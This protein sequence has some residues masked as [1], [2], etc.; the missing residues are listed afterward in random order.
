MTFPLSFFFFVS[1]CPHTLEST[2]ENSV[3]SVKTRNNF[4][5][6]TSFLFFCSCVG[7]FSLSLV[8]SPTNWAT[9][10]Q[11]SK[12]CVELLLCL[13][14]FFAQG[15]GVVVE[16]EEVGR[17]RTETKIDPQTLKKCQSSKCWLPTLMME[18]ARLN[19]CG[20]AIEGGGDSSLSRDVL[21]LWLTRMNAFRNSVS[22][23]ALICKC[24]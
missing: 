17:D 11:T 13:L 6:Q 24:A 19:R 10:C 3:E 4:A 22:V 15:R 9:E 7:V 14:H 2:A 8:N 23:P 18:L 5:A 21:T 12:K 1:S 20:N 16:R